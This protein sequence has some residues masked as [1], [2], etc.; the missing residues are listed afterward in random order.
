MTYFD[1]LEPEDAEQPETPEGVE[2][3]DGDSPES[4]DA[5]LAEGHPELE[6]L[7]KSIDELRRELQS[8][9]IDVN[10]YTGSVT[11]LIEKAAAGDADANNELWA[12]TMGQLEK[13]AEK[14][15]KGFS[16]LGWDPHEL[17]NSVFPKLNARLSEDGIQNRRHFYATACLNCRW[18]ILEE[19]DNLRRTPTSV[20][21]ENPGDIV[22]PL[23]T[24]N[25]LDRKYLYY[26]LVA[27]VDKLPE[28]SREIIHLLFMM[29]FGFREIGNELGLSTMNVY[30]QYREILPRL[31]EMLGDLN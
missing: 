21:L 27:T 20:S 16:R 23:S 26:H 3:T 29:G 28:G 18:R 7:E 6:G 17:I 13:V 11:M 1:L 25:F 2:D 12:K 4:E 15:L 9:P 31:R 8:E 22:D 19:I 5:D 14:A 30:R 10:E 24:D